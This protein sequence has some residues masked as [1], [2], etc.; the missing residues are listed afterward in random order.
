MSFPGCG[1]PCPY[2]KIAL[3][4]SLCSEEM[5]EK[6][7]DCSLAVAIWPT[8]MSGRDNSVTASAVLAVAWVSLL[9]SI[10][11]KHLEI[12]DGIKVCVC[13]S[14]SVCVSSDKRWPENSE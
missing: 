12:I 14:F 6:T 7:N 2:S 9:P 5:R 13:V 1:D 10:P 3:N 11:H 8:Y 4:I